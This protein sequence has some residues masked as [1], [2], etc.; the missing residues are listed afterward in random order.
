M[1]VSEFSGKPVPSSPAVSRQVLLERV[2]NNDESEPTFYTWLCA[3][4]HDL[5]MSNH[6]RLIQIFIQFE[7]FFFFF[8]RY[9]RIQ[10]KLN[11]ADDN[12][13]WRE[14]I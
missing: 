1:A 4:T 12:Y 3:G 8:V 13:S 2:Y 11:M 6:N 9:E 7:F 14:N 5:T 10:M